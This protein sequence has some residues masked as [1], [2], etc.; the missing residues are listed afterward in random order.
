MRSNNSGACQRGHFLRY[1]IP[2]LVALWCGGER[3]EAEVGF[4]TLPGVRRIK[5]ISADG[6]VAVGLSGAFDGSIWTL[7]DGVTELDVPSEGGHWEDI[8]AVSPDGSVIVGEGRSAVGHREA[9]MWTA[10]GGT[11]GLGDLDGG[12][13]IS[14]A[15]RVSDDG[16]TVVGR[17]ESEFD[18][19]AFRWTASDGMVG[20]GLSSTSAY[21]SADG[22]VVAV[23]GTHP[24][25][26][27]RWTADEGL[28]ELDGP[29]STA[30][31]HVS[32][33]SADG[34]TIVG[35]GWD[36]GPTMPYRWTESEGIVG[37][38]LLPIP[39]P[40]AHPH[41]VSTDG[42]VVVGEAGHVEDGRTFRWTVED[43]LVDLGMI[44]EGIWSQPLDMTPDGSIVVGQE[45]GSD[46]IYRAFI[47]DE[48]HGKRDIQAMLVDD[49]GLDLGGMELVEA[50]NISDDG[51]VIFGN[52]YIPGGDPPCWRAVIPEPSS[53]AML[54][55]GCAAIVGYVWRRR[56][57]ARR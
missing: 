57:R 30:N 37:L 47:W 9:F 53:L 3:A 39:E 1:S 16:T 43:G 11:I 24:K 19:E 8:R 27:F 40:S 21:A 6:S 50:L 45:M 17:S 15:Y 14:A 10:E 41:F 28:V 20:L 44:G 42:S 26:A 34:S 23:F 52:G 2:C 5:D 46:G 55:F 31:N 38:G 32:G 25:S 51:R 7:A 12:R 4:Q 49:Y 13:F 33:I 54:C 18:S 22:S 29:D 56:P 36:D 48:V 35:Y